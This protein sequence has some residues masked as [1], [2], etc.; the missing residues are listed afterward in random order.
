[1]PLRYER[2]QHERQLPDMVTLIEKD[3]SEPYSVY[4]YRYF[5]QQW[6]ELCFLVG[7]F[8]WFMELGNH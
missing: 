6:P 2:Y 3:L 1:M 8:V 7:L 4:T 5:L